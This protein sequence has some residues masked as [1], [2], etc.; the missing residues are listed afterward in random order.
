M[1]G[2]LLSSLA[3]SA[4]EKIIVNPLQEVMSIFK[5]QPVNTSIKTTKVTTPRGNL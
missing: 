4:S 5:F 3:V 1:I 2:I